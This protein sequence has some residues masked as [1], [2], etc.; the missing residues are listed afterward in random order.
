MTDTA[1]LEKVVLVVDLAVSINDDGHS[2]S[3]YS[4][5][6]ESRSSTDRSPDAGEHVAQETP[7][8][9]VRSLYIY[10]KAHL[11]VTP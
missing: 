3:Q 9:E 11:T 5:T 1:P 10:E 8:S 7:Q 2:Q 6:G 4:E